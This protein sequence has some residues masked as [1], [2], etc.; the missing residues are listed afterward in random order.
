LQ[1]YSDLKMERKEHIKAAKELG[2]S[3]EAIEK[4]KVAKSSI[5]M[6]NIL[7]NERRKHRA[8]ISDLRRP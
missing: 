2:Y 1:Q 5:E 8:D 7:A 3:K 6:D 4:L